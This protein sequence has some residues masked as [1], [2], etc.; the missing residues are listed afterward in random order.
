MV[1]N[2]LANSQYAWWTFKMNAGLK[3]ECISQNLV[4]IA[5]SK[6][7]ILRENIDFSYR[8]CPLNMPFFWAELNSVLVL[9]R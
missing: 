8:F 7:E 5:T 2:T 3:D 1:L 4:K 6:G 9:I